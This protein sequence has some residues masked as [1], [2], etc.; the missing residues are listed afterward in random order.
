MEDLAYVIEPVQA[1][2]IKA[3]TDRLQ[4]GMPS[5]LLVGTLLKALAASKPSSRLLELG[6]GTGLATAWLLAGMDAASTLISVD[7][8]AAVQ[9]VARNALGNDLRLELVLSDGIEFL[10]MQKPHSFDL[11][12]ADAMPGKYEG[13]EDALMVVKLGGFYVIDDMLP[14]PNWPDGHAAKIPVLMEKLAHR[15]D[16][17]LL[18]LVWS[19]GVAVA[20]RTK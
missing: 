13:L 8:D 11:V 18:P 10:R 9:A 7:T 14:Q 15:S 19:S 6:T 2:F 16:F 12:F 4:F 17:A 3:E 1:S 5:E 20:V